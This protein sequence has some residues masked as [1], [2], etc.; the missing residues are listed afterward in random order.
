MSIDIAAKAVVEGMPDKDRD[1]WITMVAIFGAESGYKLW[2]PGDHLS[3]FS[4]ADQI[5]YEP[6]ACNGYLSHGL[7]QVFLGVHHAMVAEMSDMDRPCALAEWLYDPDNNVRACAAIYAN[8][9]GFTPWYTFNGGQYRA[10]IPQATI[11]VDA[12]LTPPVVPPPTLPMVVSIAEDGEEVYLTFDN[13]DHWVLTR[14]N[15]R[16]EDGILTFD[17]K[18]R[19]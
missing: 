4:P 15:P 5:K 18:P 1:T 2:A 6:Y 16:F 7:G 12:V 14:K 17:V 11:A 8:S 19:T 3:I 10:F 9:N 13:N